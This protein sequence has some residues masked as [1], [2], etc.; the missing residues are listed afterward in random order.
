[1]YLYKNVYMRAVFDKW[2]FKENAL[3]FKS[4]QVLW[5][6]VSCHNYALIILSFY[7]NTRIQW[8][9]YAHTHTCVCIVC[10]DIYIQIYPLVQYPWQRQ[11]LIIEE[12]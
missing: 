7:V 9:T 3:G 4:W 11:C 6:V 12:K 10:R 5:P 1:M 2:F 8:T